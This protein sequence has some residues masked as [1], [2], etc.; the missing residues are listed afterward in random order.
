MI[1]ASEAFLVFAFD[2]GGQQFPIGLSW[3]A[4]TGN[5][6]WTTEEEDNKLSK[7]PSI[8]TCHTFI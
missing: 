1:V 8:I 5:G 4:S 2:T 7:T 6:L 3:G